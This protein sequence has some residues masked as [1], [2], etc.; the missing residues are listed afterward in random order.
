MTARQVAKRARN[1]CGVFRVSTPS[2]DRE[3]AP[4]RQQHSCHLVTL[5]SRRGSVLRAFPPAFHIYV[6]HPVAKR[7]SPEK[8]QFL[9]NGSSNACGSFRVKSRLTRYSEVRRAG[10]QVD[11]KR[12]TPGTHSRWP[13]ARFWEISIPRSR[14]ADASSMPVNAAIGSGP[15]EL[16]PRHNVPRNR[17]FR[18]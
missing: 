1:E 9:K 15:A 5:P 6:V 8:E 12:P 2:R 18:F 7:E 17:R 11:G 14:R 3:E 4:P 10:R 16:Q 13:E